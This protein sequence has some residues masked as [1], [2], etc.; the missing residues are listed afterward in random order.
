MTPEPENFD[1]LR[2]LL[3]LKRHEQPPPGYFSHFSRQVIAQIRA[4][5]AQNHRHF[6]DRMAWRL[7]WLQQWVE[8]FQAKPGLAVSFGG[9]V[10]ALLVSGMIYSERGDFKPASAENL[11]AAAQAPIVPPAPTFGPGNPSGASLAVTDM[12]NSLSP[13]LQSTGSLFDQFRPDPVP[14]NWQWRGNGN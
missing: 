13:I 1:G 14:V 6:F 12:T 8:A 2:R 10:F 5:E 4:D 7:P 9:A 3:K 11:A